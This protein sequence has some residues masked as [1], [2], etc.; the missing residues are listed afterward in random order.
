[1]ITPDTSKIEN[2]NFFRESEFF[3]KYC[4]VGDIYKKFTDYL[5]DN[6]INIEVSYDS[7]SSEWIKTTGYAPDIIHMSYDENDNGVYKIVWQHR[8]PLSDGNVSNLE[9]PVD[10]MEIFAHLFCV[11]GWEHEE[12]FSNYESKYGH[13]DYKEGYASGIGDIRLCTKP[14][15]EYLTFQGYRTIVQFNLFEYIKHVHRYE[16][17]NIILD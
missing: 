3:F 4:F 12:K 9:Q 1:M 5:I 15:V 14:W 6:G 2:D 7:Y 8:E 13:S 10:F 17:I 11:D 16:Q